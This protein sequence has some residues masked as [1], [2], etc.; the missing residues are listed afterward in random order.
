[1][2]P[3]SKNFNAKIQQK[4][5]QIFCFES[6]YKN[7]WQNFVA[8]MHSPKKSKW[9][10]FLF[11]SANSQWKVT[12]RW[13]YFLKAIQP[14]IISPPSGRIVSLLLI[15]CLERDSYMRIFL[16]KPLLGNP[17]LFL[18]PYF[19]RKSLASVHYFVFVLH[20]R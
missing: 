9:K 2:M 18:G 16:C 6:Y 4:F 20:P 7:L 13:L 17:Y 10:S 15:K 11:E 14:T 19:S 1:M 5:N 12:N 3:D 8:K